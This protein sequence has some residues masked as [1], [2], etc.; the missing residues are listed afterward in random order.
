[1]CVCMYVVVL[2]KCVSLKSFRGDWVTQR[3]KEKTFAFTFVN[4]EKEKRR[5]RHRNSETRLRLRITFTCSSAGSPRLVSSE[6]VRLAC[7][8]KYGSPVKQRF[9]FFFLSFKILRASFADNRQSQV[10]YIFSFAKQVSNVRYE[11]EILWYFTGWNF[12]TRRFI[13]VY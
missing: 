4:R 2:L 13:Y 12:T 5:K 10:S 8:H 1:M 9:L 11:S 3:S 6:P 7:P